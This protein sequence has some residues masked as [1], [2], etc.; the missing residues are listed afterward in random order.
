MDI[1]VF[2]IAAI[3]SIPL[4]YLT[5]RLIRFILG[6][7]WKFLRCTVFYAVR[8]IADVFGSEIQCETIRGRE[9]N[10]NYIYE[11]PL[12]FFICLG[13]TESI[14]ARFVTEMGQNDYLLNIYFATGVGFCFLYF[15]GMKKRFQNRECKSRKNIISAGTSEDENEAEYMRILVLNR[16]FMKTCIVPISFAVAVVMFYLSAIAWE[17]F[18]T[19]QWSAA[20]IGFLQEKAAGIMG[21]LIYNDYFILAA[22]ILLLVPC[23]FLIG[24]LCSLPFQFGA[25]YY[26][27]ILIYCSEHKQERQR[28]K[29][30]IWWKRLGKKI[31]K[32]KA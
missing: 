10:R 16:N 7:Y 31:L 9:L 25:Y 6:W 15:W 19:D 11:T 2:I 8:N 29:N 5:F 32:N 14:L 27:L 4:V 26:M 23:I 30:D 18:I 3:L 12:F 21:E 24:Y 28:L 1:L 13:L 17:G 20:M 22:E